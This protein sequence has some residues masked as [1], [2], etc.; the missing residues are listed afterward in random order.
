MKGYYQTETEILIETLAILSPVALILF[1]RKFIRAN[2]VARDFGARTR[3][4][5]AVVTLPKAFAS[6]LWERYS[7]SAVALKL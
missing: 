2:C 3:K 1:F 5:E 6:C 7:R 4:N